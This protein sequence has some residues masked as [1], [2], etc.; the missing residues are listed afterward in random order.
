MV[1]VGPITAIRFTRRIFGR[2][3]FV[4]ATTAAITT[5]TPGRTKTRGVMAVGVSKA[6][7]G[8]A[9]IVVVRTEVGTETLG[10]RQIQ[11]RKRRGLVLVGRIHGTGVETGSSTVLT[12]SRTSVGIFVGTAMS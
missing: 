4:F 1:G 12:R 3:R 7:G 8:S 11:I 6:V 9:V 10:T 2:K 5:E